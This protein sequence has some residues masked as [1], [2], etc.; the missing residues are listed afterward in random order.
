MMNKIFR[1][2]VALGVCAYPLAAKAQTAAPDAQTS[3]A[4]LAA[5]NNQIALLKAQVQVAQLQQELAIANHGPIMSQGRLPNLH[6]SSLM[7]LISPDAMSDIPHILSISGRGRWLKA[8]VQ[9]P[10]G[11]EM[12]VVPGSML[13]NGA[14]VQSI[15]PQSV[16]VLL[17]NQRMSLPFSS[18]TRMTLGAP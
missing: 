11:G 17:N 6:T 7:P 4:Q 2:I 5:L 14:I 10:Q 16:V 18:A 9:M 3:Y 12:M 15:T 1:I 8:L 13:S